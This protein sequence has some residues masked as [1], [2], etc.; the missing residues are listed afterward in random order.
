[1]MMEPE[2]PAEVQST[3]E[4]P[5][6]S[7]T[8]AYIAI[9]VTLSSTLVWYALSLAGRIPDIAHVPAAAVFVGSPIAVAFAAYVVA[10]I[11]LNDGAR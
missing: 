9:A 10:M 5:G 2:A 6:R 7:L 3:N 4:I 11:W 8:S 1:M